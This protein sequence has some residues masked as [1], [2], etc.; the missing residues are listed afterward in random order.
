MTSEVAS[1]L[2]PQKRRK[3]HQHT[4]VSLGKNVKDNELN[5]DEDSDSGCYIQSQ[6][7]NETL[8]RAA[9]PESAL[10]PAKNQSQ[11]ESEPPQGINIDA[12]PSDNESSGFLNNFV[13]IVLLF[14]LIT[15]FT[16]LSSDVTKLTAQVKKLQ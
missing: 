1:I 13:I 3:I 2:Q 10:E 14:K 5:S 4:S 7:D 15:S 6:G 16:K 8:L 12:R 11:R 9:D